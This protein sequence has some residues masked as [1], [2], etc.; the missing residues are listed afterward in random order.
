MGRRQGIGM[1]VEE[2]RIGNK[3]G[4]QAACGKS[5]GVWW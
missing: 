5:G 4:Q 1:V 3:A 2:G